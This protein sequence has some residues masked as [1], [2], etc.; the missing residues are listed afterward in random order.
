MSEFRWLRAARHG[1]SILLLTLTLTLA[2]P[3][4]SAQ[5][6]RHVIPSQVRGS[7]IGG[8]N[9]NTLYAGLGSG[10][11][12]RSDD[13]GLT[14]TRIVQGLVDDAGRML[15][16]KAFVTTPTGRVVRGGDNASWQN[17]AGS[18]IFVSDNQGNLWNEIPLPFASNARNPAGIAISD[19]V[20]HQGALY[21]SDLLSEG[22]WR[23][24]DNGASWTAS[25]TSLPTLPFVGFAKTYYAVASAGDALLTVEATR[26]VF[27]STDGGATWSQSVSGISGVANSPLVGGRT[28]T[29]HDVVGAPD[30]TAFAVVDSRLYRSRDGGATWTE[31]GAGILVG[32]NPFVPSVI[33][34]VVRKVELLG[35]R[36][37]VST[38]DGNP[39]F[40]EGNALDDSW[41][42]LPQIPVGG[43]TASI[44]AQSFAAHNGALYF[45][46]TNGIHRLDLASAERKA[47]PPIVSVSPTGPYGL[48]LGATLLI[49]ATARGSA[50]FSYEWRLND[51]PIPG[52][53]SA[54][55]EFVATRTDPS[56]IL[57]LVVRNAGG[58][59]NLVLGPL[60]IATTEP[61][62]IDYTFRPQTPA[63]GGISSIAFGPDATVYFVGPF[64]SSLELYAGLRK[65]FLDGTVDPAFITGAAIGN[66]TGP[67][68]GTSGSPTLVLPLSDGTVLA[69]AA[70][71][72]DGQRYYNRLTATGAIDASWPRPPELTGGP[73]K[74]VRLAN[75]QF[76]IVGGS[77]GGIHRLNADG[78]LDSSF[79]G[80]SSI[81]RL[82]RNYV[83]DLALLRDGR[84]LI[85]G[86]FNEV[87]GVP[88]VG[89]A[90]LLPNG[91]L[92]RTWVPALIPSGSEVRALAV[93]ADG[94]ILIGGAF[95][96][97]GNQPHRNLARLHE[98]G[99]VDTS[100]PDLI[101]NTTPAGVVNTL[102]LQPDGR[103]WV[104]GAFR[105]V[106]GRDSLFRLNVDGS[107]DTS[108]PDIELRPSD[109][110]P[111]PVP[112]QSLALTPDGR[113]WIG[114]TAGLARGLAAGHLF[115][116]HTDLNGPSLAFAG[117]DQTPD[118]GSPVTL[119]G[120]V[121]GPFQQVQWRFNGSPLPGANGLELPLG[122]AQLTHSGHY[123]LVA[124][125]A[126]GSH[127]SAPVQVR[128]RGPVVIDQSPASIVGI[129][130]SNATF[131][132]TAFGKLPLSYQWFFNQ[133]PLSQ[134]T[135]RT[136]NLTSL[137]AAAAGDYSV[138]VTAGDG[139][140]A[141]SDPAFLTIIPTPGSTNDSFRLALFP[142]TTFTV[143]KDIAFLPNGNVVVCG[144]F[145]ETAGG[146]NAG[147]ALLSPDGAVVPTFEFDPTD[148]TEFLAVE[149][150]PDGKIVTLLRTRFDYTVRR[151]LENGA[152]DPSFANGSLAYG[153][154]L[155][156]APDGGV[157][158]I[159]SRGISRFLPTG[160]PDEA[161]NQRAQLNGAAQ[162][163]SV[164]PSGRIYVTGIFTP[165]GST[166]RLSFLRLLPD[167]TLDSGFAPDQTFSSQWWTTAL[168]QGAL[169]GD[170]NGFYRFD[171][172]G[173]RDETYAWS[174]RLAAWD[175]NNA[176]GLI[177][178][179]PTIAGNGVLRQSDGTAAQ[180]VSSFRI[181][182]S[183]TGYAFVRVAPDGAWWLSL[184]GNGSRVAPA[185]MLFRLH[186]SVTPLALISSPVSRTVDVGTPVSLSVS[187]TG[188]SRLLYQWQRDGLPL[189]GETN[190]TLTIPATQQADAGEYTVVVSNRSGSLTSRPATLIVLGIPEI[191]SLRGAGNIG[192]G[193]TLT[194]TATVRGL[195]PLAYQWRRNGTP[196]PGAQSESFTVRAIRRDDSG[197]YDLVVSNSKGS[198]TSPTVPVHVFVLPGTVIG[199]FTNIAPGSPMELNV[200]PNGH[201]LVDG[202]AYNR[203]GELQFR[204]SF[205]DGTSTVLRDRIVVDAPRQRIYA[206]PTRRV[207]AYGLDGA[208]IEGFAGPPANVRSVRVT[209][210]GAVLQSTEG[211]NLP[212][213]RLD[214][215]GALDPGF[216]AAVLPSL[217]AYPLPDGKLLVLT[218]SQRTV[219]GQ[220]VFN[221]ILDRLH[222][223]GSSDTSFQRVTNVFPKGGQANRMQLDR[224]GHILALGGRGTVEQQRLVRLRPDGTL[225]ESF[226]P[227][228]INGEITAAVE[229]RNG[230]W[231]IVGAFTEVDGAA[232][233][234]VARLNRDG[235]HDDT[236]Q[237]GMGLTRTSGQNI[238]HDV[239]L[240]PTGE[241]LITGTFD[242]ANG[243]PRN[244]T[245][246]L[247][248]D[249]L[250][251]YFT[252]EPADAV[253]T[254]GDS[255]TLASA[256]ES[257]SPATFQW[258]KDGVPLE[259][260][261]S[262]TLELRNITADAAGRYQVVARNPSA[263]VT[264]RQAFIQVLVA[265][266]L[267]E[268]PAD[269]VVD[270]GATTTLAVHAT[271]L[272][273]T[274]QWRFQNTPIGN[275]TNATLTL[276][277]LAAAHAGAY[278]VV[279]S[280][281]A[282]SVTSPNA[283]LRVRPA[284]AP[285]GEF[286][287]DGIVGELLFDGDFAERSK[288]FITT[289]KGSPSLVEGFDGKQA[290]R[291]KAGTDWLQLG[292][293]TSRLGGTA[294][295]ASFWIRPEERGSLNVYSLTMFVGSA[296]R[297]HYL[298]LGGDDAAT[299]GQRVF[300]AT[301]GLTSVHSS[302]DRAYV[303]NLMGRW[304][305]VVVTYAGGGPSQ[306]QNFAVYID[307]SR[308]ELVNSSNPIAGSGAG[309]GLGTYAP[310]A[311]FRLDDFRL[312]SRPLSSDEVAQLHKPGPPSAKPA[313]LQQPV[314]GSVAT[315]AAFTFSVEASGT[316]LFYEWYRGNTL[317]A[318]ADGPTL[319]LTSVTPA[320][321]GDY[322][323]IVYN[324]A[325]S[326]SSSIAT[327]AV[328]GAANPF[329]DWMTG[330]GVA[331]DRAH[332]G[333][334]ADGDGA[335]NLAE[336]VYG[337]SPIAATE[338]PV[339]QAARS[340]AP[341]Q[342][343][344]AVE[345]VRRQNPGNARVE[346]QVSS[347]ITFH[348]GSPAEVVMTEPLG[349]GLE[350]VIVQGPSNLNSTP[351][352]FFRFTVRGD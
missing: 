211:I 19:L 269:S 143:F 39:R 197:S 26:G 151:L 92:D 280:N 322:K 300:L 286:P 112:V 114:S 235:S 175:L 89:I 245:V 330:L 246:L 182:V 297:E 208:L 2:G 251:L 333:A 62:A 317:L 49:H 329:S 101:P 91:A 25:G 170:L 279:V 167:G 331:G 168:P 78:T 222:P 142:T 98:D 110:S 60:S 76:L 158:A 73:R 231:V 234:L 275:A 268:P 33:Q 156:L 327:L 285:S 172:N 28:W 68:V 233:H 133:S 107:V 146:P 141:I 290:A 349:N 316:D 206:G 8:G 265:P 99:S 294:Y 1:A 122:P 314:G 198:T 179:L 173:R 304:T 115:K 61:G 226:R 320:D 344:A 324:P 274:Y 152:V 58:T 296:G 55:L 7:A 201:F 74:M 293:G 337:T 224:N 174:S 111:S 145:A 270:A 72:S 253:L 90:R 341:G 345:F 64:A 14:W 137:S 129:L 21:F 217:D 36:V 276:T 188:T 342:N 284:P 148:A 203:F 256:A 335:S 51:Q 271:G 124:T 13:N 249:A 334:D 242:R 258:L 263:E 52:Q 180:P 248:G 83:L 97:V 288:R 319:T 212:F 27:R 238:A 187:A 230:R 347:S 189:S 77:A 166:T 264:S 54:T 223:N 38:T 95:L 116:I 229:Q 260:Q 43:E 307:G 207:R 340:N 84:I 157:L 302:D 186:G 191:L 225:D 139:S 41:S 147:I 305:H 169:V 67:G 103:V 210:D 35:D 295:S 283:I 306:A 42:E 96:T 17:K 171:E 338:R 278:A 126:T 325:G 4:S 20:W 220:I 244:G 65:V 252:Q 214:A 215:T 80:P 3:V 87:D 155:K 118:L 351:A 339:F 53:V 50:P 289:P 32:P 81:G 12:F 315:R 287:T 6:W 195:A 117:I 298:Y 318:R 123:D 86:V 272:Q 190:A 162:S 105:G 125:S 113:L 104:G 311:S 336:F 308:I 328:S 209:S 34:P 130:S 177:G 247:T 159:G 100:L 18:P 136:L 323:V 281:P 93:Q 127:T 227:P 313:I 178:I 66:G 108:F 59:T 184:G 291:F 30:G 321:A 45:A 202:A 94:K 204:L 292:T 40:F 303:P 348:D 37:Y 277:N 120:S 273:L 48:N 140:S 192:L 15:L 164:D 183:F 343:R 11:V 71:T 185:T 16:P 312:Y 85:A 109:G 24:T 193:D 153:E 310:S 44:L 31:I 232:R 149:R 121:S 352:Q 22:I 309:N 346:I 119:K 46:G 138:R 266:V 150:Q 75:G 154:D 47:L 88:R 5:G 267:V 181:P 176:G 299:Q 282:G 213:Q 161:F 163:L 194:L 237:P 228:R 221:T 63:G 205:P 239:D 326:V 106:S 134:G 254:L 132:V 219:A 262:P 10:E 196:I 301:R 79:Q 350:R 236:F 69:G 165:N 23:S 144:N 216:N 250:D 332:P 218:F 29:G 240:L 102:Q 9:G 160:Q 200:L 135:N 257:S 70:G 243:Q 131:S 56:G 259:G 57:S 199:S 261:T 255:I 241:I 128:V 82:Q